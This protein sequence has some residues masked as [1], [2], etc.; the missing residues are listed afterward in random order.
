MKE[1]YAYSDGKVMIP[2]EINNQVVDLEIRD[3]QDN[4]EQILLT[5]NLLEELEKEYTTKDLERNYFNQLI[6]SK[7]YEKLFKALFPVFIIFG[8]IYTGLMMMNTSGIIS[9][10]TG[11]FVT[12]IP[13]AFLK[14]YTEIGEKEAINKTNA[15]N[16]ELEELQKVVKAN[17][18]KLEELKKDKKSEVRP[19]NIVQV[20]YK[21]QLNKLKEYLEVCYKIGYFE[22]EY[23]QY[24][25]AGILEE[26]LQ[27]EMS[28]NQIEQI[29]RYFKRKV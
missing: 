1:T 13:T 9:T 25:N 28:N 22:E 27:E 10:L 12:I 5:E 2:V 15:I 16:L 18:E 19:P 7:F 14:F 24:F 6:N 11:L 17:K 4:L 3:Y 29:K 23:K 21:Y 26:K 20:N 8:L